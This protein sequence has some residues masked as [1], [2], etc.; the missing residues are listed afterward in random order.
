LCPLNALVHR[1]HP[2][3]AQKNLGKILGN[4]GDAVCGNNG[5]TYRNKCEMMRDGCNQRIDLRVQHEG[6]CD[7]SGKYTNRVVP[8]L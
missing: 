4:N 8:L 1:T 2:L 3:S 6:R 5:R 7:E